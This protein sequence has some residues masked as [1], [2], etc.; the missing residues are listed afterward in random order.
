MVDAPLISVII[1]TYNSKYIEDCLKSCLGQTIGMDALEIIMVDD[2]S[3]DDT[4]D[5][6]SA[7]LKGNPIQLIQLSE[8]GGPAAARNAG[9]KVARG[10]FVAFLDSDD[11]M[12]PEKLEK[13]LKYC[14]ANPSI[15]AVISG[16]EEID[17]HGNFIRTLVRLFPEDR[18][19][20]VEILFLDNLHTITSTLFFKRS[21]LGATGL[22]DPDLLNLE[23]MEFALKLLKHTPMYY[24]PEGMTIRRV[25]DTGLSYT[26]SETVFSESREAFLASA[27]L[28]HP[29]LNMRVRQ[30]WYL[31]YS[32][33]GRVL[34]R[35]G[36]SRRARHYYRESM[37]W[38]LSPLG[39]L[40]FVLSYFPVRFQSRLAN[41]T[42]KRK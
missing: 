31:N 20:Q 2:A 41:R 29:D 15:Q 38:Q 3:T 11:A 9:L 35:Q 14:E 39:V 19:E 25:L 12:K 24:F 23:D 32:R 5:R 6:V 33:L 8:N 40:G 37:K 34:Q 10:K 16:I 26:A 4:V 42:W 1:P 17:L 21:L 7:L 36:D 22:M 18:S 28:I 13:Q 30:Y 27:L